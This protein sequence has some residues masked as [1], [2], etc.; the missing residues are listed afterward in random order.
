ML[1]TEQEKQR[2][3]N[4]TTPKQQNLGKTAAQKFKFHLCHS[5]QQGYILHR[6]KQT[7]KLKSSDK[8]WN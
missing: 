8:C 7:G 5:L 1:H 6:V 2:Q 3:I 4:Q